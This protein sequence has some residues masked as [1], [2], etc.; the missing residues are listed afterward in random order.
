ME[1]QVWVEM[2]TVFSLVGGEFASVDSGCV[3]LLTGGQEIDR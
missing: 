2:D 3:C 1:F